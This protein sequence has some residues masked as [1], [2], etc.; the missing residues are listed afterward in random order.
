MAEIP[1]VLRLRCQVCGYEMPDDATV[2]AYQL[3]MQVEHDTDEVR[4]DLA[5]I[6]TCGASMRLL[7]TRETAEGFAD[8]FGCDFDGNRTT[9][10]RGPGGGS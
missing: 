1:P 9:V 3:H 7:R 6:C 8:R 5:V 10:R 2:E 4:L